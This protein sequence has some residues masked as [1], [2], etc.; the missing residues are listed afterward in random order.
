MVAVNPSDIFV[1]PRLPL[2]PLAEPVTIQASRLIDVKLYAGHLS[3]LRATQAKSCL[4]C[5]LKDYLNEWHQA[6]S[7]PNTLPGSLLVGDSSP[8]CPDLLVLLPEL[9]QQGF[10]LCRSFAGRAHAQQVLP[11]LFTDAWLY[12]S[13]EDALLQALLI[14]NATCNDNQ[15]DYMLPT[16]C[17]SQH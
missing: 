4:L 16:L 3:L 10:P 12:A 8:L 17:V 7:G 9:L 14:H 5:Y 13:L 2:P 15:A 11:D 6:S 1:N